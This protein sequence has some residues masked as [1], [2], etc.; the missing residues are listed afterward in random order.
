MKALNWSSDMEFDVAGVKFRCMVNDYTLKT[1]EERFILLKDRAVLEQY[2]TVL[3]ES[4]PKN[5]L[6]FGIFQGGS[7]ALF[8]LWLDLEKFAAIDISPPI[9]AFDTFCRTDEIGHR[10]RPHYRV[11]QTD[12][13]RIRDIVQ[14]EFGTSPLDVIIDDASH[15]Y[16][17]SRRT[18]EIAFPL[19]RPGGIYVIEDWGWAHWPDSQFHMGQTPLSM[20]IM[21]I[22][23]LCASRSDLVSDIR[24]FPAF[25]FIRKA[26][27][28]PPT[29]ELNLSSLYNKRGIELVGARDAD[30]GAIVRLLAKRALGATQREITR[31][32]ENFRRR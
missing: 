7:P 16:A 30:I 13:V 29:A 1:N 19:L 12:A 32:V 28:A 2:A 23:M 18:F 26:P 15:L 4:A 21:E 22:A 11:S 20:L 5:I 24:L 17:E 25:A 6:E 10:I 9:E 31:M 27:E 3:A 8:T 14:T